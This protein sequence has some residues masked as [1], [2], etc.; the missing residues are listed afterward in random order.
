MTLSNVNGEDVSPAVY[1]SRSNTFT[2]FLSSDGG[3]TPAKF[4]ARVRKGEHCFVSDM[5]FGKCESS[6]NLL[7]CLLLLSWQGHGHVKINHLLSTEDMSQRREYES[8]KRQTLK[9]VSFVS[10]K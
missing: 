6:L 10:R 1:V 9:H 2:F 3:N 5:S 8:V 4:R 7:S